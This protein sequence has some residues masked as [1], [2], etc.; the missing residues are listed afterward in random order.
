MRNY[1]D[2]QLTI[3]GRKR[4]VKMMASYTVTLVTP[5]GEQQI[6]CADDAYLVDAAEEAGIDLPYSCRAGACSSCVGKVVSG[7]VDNS[8]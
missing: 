8:E 3:T 2:S 7:T 6:E 1:F 5:D 4:D